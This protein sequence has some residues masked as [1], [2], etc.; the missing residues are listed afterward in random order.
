MHEQARELLSGN[1]GDQ[2]FIRLG[3]V[4]A[5]DMSIE[6]LLWKRWCVLSD[7]NLV[8]RYPHLRPLPAVRVSARH[9]RLVRVEVRLPPGRL[10]RGGAEDHRRADEPRRECRRDRGQDGHGRAYAPGALSPP[11]TGP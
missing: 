6:N 5:Q 10:E 3:D 9:A 7:E 8:F 11:A 1:A 4:L 2:L